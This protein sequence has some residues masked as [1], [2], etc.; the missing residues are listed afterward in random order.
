MAK[1]LIENGANIHICDKFGQ[2]ALF[3]AVSR[4]NLELVS[5]LEK[6]GA[7]FNVRGL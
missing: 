6:Q 4:G 1:I 5:L 7:D 3:Y 2:T